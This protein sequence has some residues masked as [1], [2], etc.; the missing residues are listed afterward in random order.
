MDNIPEHVAEFLVHGSYF[1]RYDCSARKLPGVEGAPS[2]LTVLTSGIYHV[3]VCT[4]HGMSKRV[5][6]STQVCKH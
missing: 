2:T 5:C 4:V 6:T 1:M 3:Y